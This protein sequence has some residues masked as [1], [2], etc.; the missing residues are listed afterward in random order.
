M[1]QE[2]SA[3]AIATKVKFLKDFFDWRMDHSASK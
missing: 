1:A 3:P 2:D